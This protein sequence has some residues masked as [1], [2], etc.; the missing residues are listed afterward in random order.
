MHH[1][2][3]LQLYSHVILLCFKSGRP[4]NKSL[5]IIKSETANSFSLGIACNISVHFY[6][7]QN[8]QAQWSRGNSNVQCVANESV[9]HEILCMFKN[10]C[11]LYVAGT[12]CEAVFQK[13]F[14]ITPVW[15]KSFHWP[16]LHC[17]C[18]CSS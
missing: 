10:T 18:T 17:T 7:W 9:D 5:I 14:W 15:D 16:W 6:K 12:Q 1:S 4:L 8:L 11:T 2:S 3:D 13:T